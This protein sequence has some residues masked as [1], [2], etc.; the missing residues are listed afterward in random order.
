M[1]TSAHDEVFT[2]Q[3]NI[4]TTD[5]T[6]ILDWTPPEQEDQAQGR[7]SLSTST[8]LEGEEPVTTKTYSDRNDRVA[9]IRYQQCGGGRR[10]IRKPL[11]SM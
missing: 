10:I 7:Q 1:L 3:G 4:M 8:V 11:G 6:L 5:R 2:K 9:G